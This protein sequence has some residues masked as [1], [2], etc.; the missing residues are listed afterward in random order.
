[1]DDFWS[2][3][4]PLTVNVIGYIVAVFLYFWDGQ[5]VGNP[6]PV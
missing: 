4:N 5:K 3:N 6:V 2:V 1:M